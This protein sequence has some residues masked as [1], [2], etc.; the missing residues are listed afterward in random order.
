MEYTDIENFHGHS[1]PGLA[2]GYRMSSAAMAA[3]GLCRSGDEE[4]VAVVENDACGVD[5]LQYMTGCTFGKGNLVF[6]DYGKSVYTLFSRKSG[7]GVRVMFHGRGIPAG[8][9]EDRAAF[10]GYLLHCPDDAIIELQPVS[11]EPPPS[12]RI[13]TSVACS[14]CNEYVMETKLREFDGQSVCIPCAEHGAAA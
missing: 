12:A 3:L 11:C 4:V 9:R 7:Q 8:L 14:L 10:A 13:R 2:V 6:R 1:C 5:A